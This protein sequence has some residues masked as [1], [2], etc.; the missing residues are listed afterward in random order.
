MTEHGKCE[1]HD[2]IDNCHKHYKC[3]KFDKYNKQA[4]FGND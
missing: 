1:M 2:K 3:D 4:Q